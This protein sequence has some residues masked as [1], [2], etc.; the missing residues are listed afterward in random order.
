MKQTLIFTA[1]PYR[2]ITANDVE[3]LTLSVVVSMRLDPGSPSTLQQFPDIKS[4]ISNVKNAG[5]SV[6][7]GNMNIEAKLKDAPIDDALWSQLMH[8]KI[9]VQAFEQEDLSHHR[10]VSYPARHVNDFILNNYQKF[11]IANPKNYIPTSAFLD[12]EGLASISRYKPLSGGLLDKL[13]QN[14]R[15]KELT[16]AEV[17]NSLKIGRHIFERMLKIDAQTRFVGPDP[18]ASPATDFFQMRDFHQLDKK[19]LKIEPAKLKKPEFEFHD[20]LSI[21]SSYPQIQRKLALIL[22]LEIPYSNNLPKTGVLHLVPQHLGFEDE[23]EVSCPKVAYAI[24]NGGF[25][26]RPKQDSIIDQGFVKIN[27]PAFSVFQVD[28]DGAALKLNNQVENKIIEDAKLKI[29]N[30]NLLGSKT[31]QAGNLPE[32]TPEDSALPA[33]RSAGI[34]VAR[35]GLAEVLHSTFQQAKMHQNKLLDKNNYDG[36]LK[37][38]VPKDSDALF[39]DEVV[40]GYRM[41]IALST[42]PDTWYS[43]HWKKDQY[44]Y[45]DSSGIE[46][47]IEGIIPDEGFIQTAVAEDTDEQNLLYSAE[48]MFRWE[49]WSLSVKKPGYAINEEDEGH[50]RDYVNTS[51]TVEAQKYQLDKTLDFKLNALPQLVQG[52]LPKLRFGE[53]YMIRVRTVDMAGNSRLLQEPTPNRVQNEIRSFA[54]KRF[55]PVA[56]PIVLLGNHLRDGESLEHMVIRSNFDQ[57]AEKYEEAH[58]LSNQRFDSTATRH[59]LPPKNSQLM[60]EQH[61]KFDNAFGQHPEIAKQM[62]DFIISREG[63]FDFGEKG[64]DKVY[65]TSEVEVIYLPDPMGAGIS[66]FLADGYQTTHSQQFDQRLFAFFNNEELTGKHTDIAIGDEWHSGKSLRIVLK[67]G[68]R[69]AEWNAGQ[70]M[71][72]VTMPKGERTRLKFSTWWRA[73][74]IA[75][76]SAIWDLLRQKNPG[77]LNELKNIAES[78]QHW[79]IS[80]ARELELVHAVQQPVDAPKINTIHSTRVFDQTSADIHTSIAVHGYSTLKIDLQANWKEIIDLPHH[81]APEWIDKSGA[82]NDIS[83]DYHQKEL[84]RGSIPN[85]DTGMAP[86]NKAA[87]PAKLKIDTGDDSNGAPTSKN[88]Q[89]TTIRKDTQENSATAGNQN[90][91]IDRVQQ[92]KSTNNSVLAGY[93]ISISRPVLVQ[94]FEDTRHRRVNYKALAASRYQDYFAGLIIQD[95]LPVTRA[96]EVVTDVIILSSARPRKPEI[97]YIIPTFEWRKAKTSTAMRHRRLGGGLRIYLKRPWYSSGENEKLAVILPGFTAGQNQN[98]MVA[99]PGSGLNTQVTHWGVDPIK[100]SRPESGF[101]PL[102]DQFRHAPLIDK[103]LAYPG[104]GAYKVTAVAYPVEFDHKRKLWFCDVAIDHGLMYYP[105]IK[106]ALARYQQHSVRKNDTDVCLS[107]VV[108]ADFVQLVPERVTNL[109]FKKDDINTKFSITV[110]GTMSLIGRA[111]SPSNFIVISFFNSGLAQPIHMVIDDQTNDK[112]LEKERLVVHIGEQ[113]VANDRFVISREVKLPKDY[114]RLPFIVTIE[115]YELGPDADPKIF[116]NLSSMPSGENQPR[117]VFA[118][119]FDINAKEK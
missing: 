104:A 1:L 67:E 37:A 105:F 2:Y 65:Q 74:D 106:L 76:I 85:E 96:S 7:M 27:T 54:Y 4:W 83:I 31:L 60:A 72:L 32:E 38:I 88:Q 40:Q 66:L 84:L 73:S 30:I 86:K 57:T 47:Q 99:G 117:L 107:E 63:H 41:D 95:K 42:N 24:E 119:R 17:F 51:K 89:A 33:L 77:N 114:K 11:A 20:I 18:L 98:T 82:V 101:S 10:L 21:V 103:G 16:E 102:A 36:E 78:G 25:F 61:G 110:E 8:D 93:S 48:V 81:A 108:L 26:A 100:L 34:A 5:F 29:V 9:K 118:D 49:G 46:Y 75:Q 43:L 71:L 91:A 45:S 62:Y 68:S 39:A 64:K 94:Q 59:F 19:P 109:E 55:E 58:P 69:A 22:D 113:D 56:S 13:R 97:E 53:S 23:L 35:N 116:N 3:S 14:P 92:T 15:R 111:Y 79:M 115:E 87:Q 52:T 50:D 6:R 90:L 70:R 12:E 80:P 28:G 112:D 44:S